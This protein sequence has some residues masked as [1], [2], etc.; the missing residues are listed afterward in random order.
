M[1]YNF[2]TCN[3]ELISKILELDETATGLWFLKDNIPGT[4]LG[5]QIDGANIFSYSKNKM[6]S[7][8]VSKYY[9]GIVAVDL[10]SSCT[11]DWLKHS[12]YSQS[13]DQLYLGI[14]NDFKFSILAMEFCAFYLSL[15]I[16]KSNLE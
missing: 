2:S 9:F 14:P 13:I 11:Q 15:P 4:A 8:T 10:I 6:L 12:R 5:F 3:F 1:N 7:L 16:E